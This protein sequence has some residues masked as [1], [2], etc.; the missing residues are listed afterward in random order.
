MTTPADEPGAGDDQR[1][2]RFRAL[3]DQNY[4]DLWRY[5]LRRSD[6]AAAA[7]DALSETFT[8]AWRKL[9]DAPPPPDG[10]PWL[11]GIARNHLR[12]SWRAGKR[13]TRLTQ[14]LTAVTPGV[15]PDDPATLAMD[16]SAAV[17]AALGE[18]READQEL[19]QL[20]AWE[21]LPHREIAIILGCSEN[22][23]AIRLHRA[24]E[25]FERKLNAPPSSAR[26]NRSS[27]SK[28]FRKVSAAPDRLLTSEPNEK[29]GTAQ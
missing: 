17:L 5:C 2:E 1:V 4:D 24:R 12:N 19:L 18:L 9:D 27:R 3:Y 16:D 15:A 22:A 6:N 13:R 28:K 14:K 8:V 23:V 11:F 26:L 25:R 21:E 29:K 7:E 20:A 10:R